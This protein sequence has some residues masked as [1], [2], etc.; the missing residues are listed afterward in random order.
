MPPDKGKKRARDED[1][2]S[3]RSESPLTDLPD[4]EPGPARKYRR[5]RETRECP[6]CNERIPT[7]LLAAHADLEAERVEAIVRRIGETDIDI[8]LL[9]ALEAMTEDSTIAI[10]T[11]A[12]IRTRQSR[13]NAQTPTE[14]DR[15]LVA[16]ASHKIQAIKRH[17]KQRNIK[18]KELIRGDEAPSSSHA[19]SSRLRETW[20]RRGTTGGGACE[21]VCPICL[22]SVRGDTDVLDAHVDACLADQARRLEEQRREQM[23]D[24]RA[25]RRVERSLDVMVVDE[26]DG[27]GHVGDVRGTGFAT[28]DP[29]AQDIDD[30]IDIDGDDEEVFGGIQF[31]ERDVVNAFPATE[32][33]R[34]T[35]DGEDMEVDIDGDGEETLRELVA[36]GKVIKRDRPAQQVLD[37]HRQTCDEVDKL[38]LAILT[39]KSRGDQASL[40]GLLQS[41]IKLLESRTPSVCRI[42]IE[43]YTDPTVST[44]CWH[45]C[46]KE[47]WLRC[48]GSTKLCP[49]CK[50]ITAATDLRRIYL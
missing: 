13:G 16:E 15:D 33:I 30:E 5:Q 35:E 46:C 3:S 38:E 20:R 25:A 2:E 27:P 9:D 45:T 36:Q 24:R 42:C 6:V 17:R 18:L 19:S 39:A 43:A 34:P 50:R 12:R 31:T 32:R 26:A 7:H 48:L 4:E 11:R 47:C 28:R 21:I 40:I 49:I 41:K 8:E 22:V 29:N 1:V 10:L 44:G 23:S 14:T 37:S